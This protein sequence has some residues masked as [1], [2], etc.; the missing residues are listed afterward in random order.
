[1]ELRENTP[2]RVGR[3][4]EE[5]QQARGEQ[6]VKGN[7]MINRSPAAASIDLSLGY[8][9]TLSCPKTLHNIQQRDRRQQKCVYVCLHAHF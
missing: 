6:G 5:G 9:S 1:M 7:I 2:C 8:L 4:V 3:A